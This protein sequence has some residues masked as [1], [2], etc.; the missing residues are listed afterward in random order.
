M[1]VPAVTFMLF[2]VGFSGP[3]ICLTGV[4]AGRWWKGRDHPPQS[5]SCLYLYPTRFPPYCLPVS[6]S[7]SRQGDGHQSR[8]GGCEKHEGECCRGGQRPCGHHR[9]HCAEH[10]PANDCLHYTR[11]A[12][13]PSTA[14]SPATDSS[15]SLYICAPPK[16]WEA[17]LRCCC[18]LRG[19]LWLSHIT[20]MICG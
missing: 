1:L 5:F 12:G 20:W 14:F 18:H 9:E 8:N 11:Y 2:S 16:P 7:V 3:L 15:H 6:R 17:K 13:L 10:P 19:S 4:S